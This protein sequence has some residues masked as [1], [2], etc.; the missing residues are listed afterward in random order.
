M[1]FDTKII[2]G[3]HPEDSVGCDYH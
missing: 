3:R 2:F 1:H